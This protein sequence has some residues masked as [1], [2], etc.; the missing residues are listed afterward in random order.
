[1]TNAADPTA[2]RWRDIIADIIASKGG[3]LVNRFVA[4]R[5]A[6]AE[7]A[8][9]ARPSYSVVWERNGV[10][11]RYPTLLLG[12]PEHLTGLTWFGMTRQHYEPVVDV[13]GIKSEVWR[14]QVAMPIPLLIAAFLI[15]PLFSLST[16]RRRKRRAKA[17]VDEVSPDKPVAPP[18]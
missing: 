9:F 16:S 18:A 15:W 13:G 14:T 3:L 12:V 8:A 11:P 10:L 4:Y 7:V 2:P 6:E 1:M 17:T 5:E